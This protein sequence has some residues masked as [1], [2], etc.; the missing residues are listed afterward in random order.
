MTLFLELAQGQREEAYCNTP[1]T[2]NKVNLF[3]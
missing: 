1:A 3:M 2:D